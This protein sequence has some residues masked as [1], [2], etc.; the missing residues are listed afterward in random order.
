MTST[1][2]NGHKVNV[3]DYQPARC[4]LEMDADSHIAVIVKPGCSVGDVHDMLGLL[5]LCDGHFEH[6]TFVDDDEALA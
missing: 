3:S 1:T 6:L 2:V 4:I 5:A